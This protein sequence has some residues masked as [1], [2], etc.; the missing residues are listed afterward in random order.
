MSIQVEGS[1]ESAGIE[2]HG[3][4]RVPPDKRTH[5]RIFDNFTLW[6]SANLVLPALALGSLATGIFK[7]GFWDS[8]IVIVLFNILGILPV[9]FFSTLGP[10]LGLRQMT[11]S[12]FSFGWVGAKI[13]ALFNVAACI[14]WSAVNVILGGE[15][16]NKIT[17][18]VVPGW[19]GILILA[20]LT[21][22]IALYG[23]NYVHRYERYAWLPMLF[24]FAIIFVVS[25]PDFRPLT[26]NA[27]GWVKFAS[28]MSFGSTVYGFATGWSSYAADY[29]VNQP[30]TTNSNHVFWLTFL[31]CFLPL[32]SLEIL[33]LA[34][35]TTPALNG[36]LGGALF[37]AAL[38]PMGSFGNLLLVFLTLSIIAN[39][40][41]NDYSLALSIQVLGGWFQRVNRVVWTLV[42]S[43]IYVII[44]I[45]AADKFSQT[46]ESFLLLV[47]YWLGPWSII[48]IL[49]HFIFRQGIYNVD[50]WNTPRKLPNGW[51]ALVSLFIGLFGVYLGAAQEKFVGPIAGLVNQ[52]FGIDIGFELGAI[53]AGIAYLLLRRIELQN[54]H[55]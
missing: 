10:K 17:N 51:A 32:V 6:A 1:I 41:P 25:A 7:L 40:I 48:L 31:G 4:E 38:S 42:G 45:A 35:T 22:Y 26:S 36:K 37:S 21:T 54:N 12:R 16:V 34:L 15:L 53:M 46:L 11:I 44:G 30:E 52:P 39:N 43:L 50:D 9:A 24:V 47:A 13:M 49:E 14:G 55:R 23:Y 33:G 18:G 29:S 2:L 5:L 3:I 8:V 19:A 20:A 27:T 28:F